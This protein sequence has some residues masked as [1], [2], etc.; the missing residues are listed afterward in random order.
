MDHRFLVIF[1]GQ[2]NSSPIWSMPDHWPIY[3][4]SFLSKTTCK[5]SLN[6]PTQPLVIICKWSVLIN[7]NNYL[8]WPTKLSAIDHPY[9]LMW[10]L[11]T[12]HDT[13]IFTW[14]DTYIMTWHWENMAW[15]V[16]DNLAW[17][18]ITLFYPSSINHFSWKTQT[19]LWIGQHMTMTSKIYVVLNSKLFQINQNL[20]ISPSTINCKPN[21]LPVR[22]TW[23]LTIKNF[24]W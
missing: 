23:P 21:T 7:Q 5:K 24:L 9:W 18:V 16:D 20:T 14:H 3:C 11:L 10:P 8:I 13:W 15:H 19:S 4:R 17:H 1:N 2:W 12:W 22:L 6:R